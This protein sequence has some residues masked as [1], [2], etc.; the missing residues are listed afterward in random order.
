VKRE[1]PPFSLLQL[2]R[3]I[4]TGR[5]DANQPIDLTTLCNTHVYKLNPNDREFGINLTDE[6]CFCSLFEV[7]IFTLVLDYW[8]VCGWQVK[9]VDFK[10][11]APHHYGFKSC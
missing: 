10:P 4:D 6:V 1:Y 8:D 7:L 2:Q 9:V 5:I 11:L 3:L